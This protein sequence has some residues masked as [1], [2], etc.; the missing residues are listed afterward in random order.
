MLDQP[1]KPLDRGIWWI[2]HVLQPKCRGCV[3]DMLAVGALI[4]RTSS[5]SI[6]S[7]ISHI[8]SCSRCNLYKL[9]S[10]YYIIKAKVKSTL[11]IL[12][13]FFYFFLFWVLFSYCLR[14]WFVY[15]QDSIPICAFCSAAVS[16]IVS[17]A[18]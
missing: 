1:M 5:R 10:R 3:Y 7:L 9:V 2:E 18:I 17:C 8:F 11:H 4:I 15:A 12:N 16:C 13:I 14:N 6:V